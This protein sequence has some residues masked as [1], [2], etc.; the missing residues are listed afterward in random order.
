[1]HKEKGNDDLFRILVPDCRSIDIDTV[2]ADTNT[3]RFSSLKAGTLYKFAIKTFKIANGQTITSTSYSQ[4]TAKTVPGAV[5]YSRLQESM[6][7]Q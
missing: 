2:S 3:Y 1:M 6:L 4:L 7:T 5:T